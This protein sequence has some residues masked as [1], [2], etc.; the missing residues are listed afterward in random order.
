MVFRPVFL[1]AYIIVSLFEIKLS[2]ESH[3]LLFARGEQFLIPSGNTQVKGGDVVLVFAKDEV[4]SYIGNVFRT[5]G[6]TPI[7]SS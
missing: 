3:R 6:M 7:V 5:E 2:A 1:S 4:I